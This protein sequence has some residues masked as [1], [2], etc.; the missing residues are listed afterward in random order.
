MRLAV[1]IVAGSVFLAG[2][3]W[4]VPQYLEP[5]PGHGG[6]AF[7]VEF[8]GH[9]Y[10]GTSARRQPPPGR[11]L[12]TAVQPACS[13]IAPADPTV[14]STTLEVFAI[15]GVDPAVAVMTGTSLLLRDG[16]RPLPPAL[17]TMLTT[18]DCHGT[19]ELTGQVRDI[20]RA[21]PHPS[22]APTTL[23]LQVTD[24]ALLEQSRWAWVEV[25]VDVPPGTPGADRL[26]PEVDMITVSTRCTGDRFAATSVRVR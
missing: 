12:G 9:Q 26:T 2:L 4:V 10:V 7:V 25:E 1:G 19:L 14:G 11:S 16:E 8:E 22:A 21:S 17:R 6:C 18:P 20:E 13:D 3:V 5:R 15:P 23:R 24:G